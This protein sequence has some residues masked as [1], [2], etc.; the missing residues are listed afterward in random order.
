M[1]REREITGIYL[2]ESKLDVFCLKGRF[3]KWSSVQLPY[4]FD[5]AGRSLAEQLKGVLQAIRPSR[6]R[7]ICLALPRKTLFLRELSFPQLE[8]DEATDAVRMGIGLH[9]H[10]KPDEIYHDQWAFKRGDE[11]I[12]L[13]AYI[14][15]SFL[16]PVLRVVHE[17]GHGKSLGPI[18]PA[19]LGLDILLRSSAEASLPC[20][21]LGRQG[22]GWCVSLHGVYGWEG[23]HSVSVSDEE[24]VSMGLQKLA[25]HLPF[26]FSKLAIAP[27]Y[28]VGDSSTAIPDTP[29]KDPYNA[30]K[31]LLSICGQEGK[32][33]WGLC[34]A[35]LGLSSYP[36]ISFQEG[37]RRKPFRLSIKPYQFV[38][39][40]AVAAFI[41]VTG[42]Q[43][44]QFQQRVHSIHKMEQDVE[45][46]QERLSPMLNTRKQLEQIENQLKDL[47][48]FRV[49]RPAEL[50]VLK[51]IAELTPPQTWIKNFNIKKDRLKVTAEGGSAVKTMGKWRQSPLFLEVKLISPVTKDRQQRERF[52]V[53][54]KLAGGK[55]GASDGN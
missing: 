34:A 37:I 41:L 11:T 46:L 54:M 1:V 19:T 20:V 4:K 10:L 32:V 21:S 55:G 35:L 28:A 33:T 39:G 3:G 13:L 29:P 23:S 44:L 42:F 6:R 8:P 47:G 31:D 43:G 49:E 50:K 2:D 53:E 36:A 16:D 38:V 18:S 24:D 5:D 27:V 25:Q 12:V 45:E 48:D 15:R 17:T 9:I 51:A 40:A 26:P 22:D 30:I 7:K 52:T 14:P